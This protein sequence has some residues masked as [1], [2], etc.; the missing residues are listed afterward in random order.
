M[1]NR[2]FYISRLSK[3]RDQPVIKI[4]TGIRRSG[5][6]TLIKLFI[7]HLLKSGVDKNRIVY[8]NKESF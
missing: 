8:I 6:S 4:I 5:K 7:D 1:H 2:K 3:W